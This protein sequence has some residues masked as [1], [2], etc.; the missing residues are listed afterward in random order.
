M[1][2]M[3]EHRDKVNIIL[4]T[5]GTSDLECSK[6]SDGFASKARCTLIRLVETTFDEI[7][8]EVIPG[9]S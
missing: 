9:G 4:L 2:T 5:L 1:G 7:E 6:P 8:Q 3:E